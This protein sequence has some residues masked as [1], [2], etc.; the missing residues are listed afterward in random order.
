MVENLYLASLRA[1]SLPFRTEE[2]IDSKIVEIANQTLVRAIRDEAILKKMPERYVNSIKA[3]IDS[4][5][6]W[7]WVDFKGENGEPLD[8]FFEEG[9][10]DH[11]IK[12]RNKKALHGGSKWPYFSKGHKVSGIKARHVF[13]DGL[14]KGYPEFKKLLA[15]ETE[16]YLE[17]TM[18]FG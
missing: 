7:V 17:E 18:L 5:E 16:K 12:P 15:E 4:G 1:Q 9:T 3:E 2:F 6:L 13:R 8:W 11:E 10:K 14:K